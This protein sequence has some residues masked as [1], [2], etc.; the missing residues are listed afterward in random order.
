MHLFVY[1]FDIEKNGTC[2]SGNSIYEKSVSQLK[3]S[4]SLNLIKRTLKCLPKSKGVM[5]AL[6][7]PASQEQGR[8]GVV[9]ERAVLIVGSPVMGEGDPGKTVFH[10]LESQ[11]W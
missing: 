2:F 11:P 1:L 10:V 4:S 7:L 8:W 3:V 6:C 5:E 9:V